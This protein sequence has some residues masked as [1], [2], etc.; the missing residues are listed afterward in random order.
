MPRKLKPLGGLPALHDDAAALG[1]LLL[2]LKEA[3]HG[4]RAREQEK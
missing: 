3:G 4:K 1:S 2:A